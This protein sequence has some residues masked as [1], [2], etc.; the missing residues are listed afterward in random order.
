MVVGPELGNIGE[1]SDLAMGK[2]LAIEHDDS[3]DRLEGRSATPGKDC[4]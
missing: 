4:G 3:L 2:G 1:E